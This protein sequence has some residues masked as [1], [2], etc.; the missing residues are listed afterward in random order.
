MLSLFS[1][2]S[3]ATAF[4]LIDGPLLQRS[5]SVKRVTTVDNVPMN[6][7]LAPQL[8]EGKQKF[9]WKDNMEC[10][11]ADTFVKHLLPTTPIILD[12]R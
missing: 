1:I 2:A 7:S 9:R 5:S 8:P 6:I 11:L 4:V 12:T 10:L 3:F